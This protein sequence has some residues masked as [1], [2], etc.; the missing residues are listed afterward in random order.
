MRKRKKQPARHLS[1]EQLPRTPSPRGV[2]PSALVPAPHGGRCAGAPVS[3]E[4]MLPR[5]Q[6]ERQGPLAL[7]PEQSWLSFQVG[8]PACLLMSLS[9]VFFHSLCTHPP[10][11]CPLCGQVCCFCPPAWPGDAHR[12]LWRSGPVWTQP[13]RTWPLQ[14]F[15][16]PGIAPPAQGQVLGENLNFA[17]KFQVILHLVFFSGHAQIPCLIRALAAVCAKKSESLG[18]GAFRNKPKQTL[19]VTLNHTFSLCLGPSPRTDLQPFSTT[20]NLLNY[21]SYLCCS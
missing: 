7:A 3:Q 19:K 8:G 20:W 5:H 6:A 14:A 9:H 4:Q 15:V 11:A 10:K 12:S 16:V 21:P 2:L 17:P 18:A 1:P 13:R